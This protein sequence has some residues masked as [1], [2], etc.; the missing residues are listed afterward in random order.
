MKTFRDQQ[1]IRGFFRRFGD[2][3]ISKADLAR[4]RVEVTGNHG[5]GLKLRIFH[6]EKQ[7]VDLRWWPPNGASAAWPTSA[8]RMFRE[9]L[10]T[11]VDTRLTRLVRN[12]LLRHNL[13]GED[14]RSMLEVDEEIETIVLAIQSLGEA[15]QAQ[16]W[17]Y[18]RQMWDVLSPMKEIR[19]DPAFAQV[20]TWLKRQQFFAESRPKGTH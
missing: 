11:R 1:F 10:E 2:R 9:A 18:A 12:F 6:N 13:V 14:G 20:G 3:P 19:N 17:A 8:A 5:V 4:C 15:I 16:E 7:L